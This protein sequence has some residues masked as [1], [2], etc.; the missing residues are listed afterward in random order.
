MKRLLLVLCIAVIFA[1]CKANEKEADQTA[2]NVYSE[3]EQEKTENDS[4]S[5][6]TQ[7]LESFDTVYKTEGLLGAIDYF[8]RQYD[9]FNEDQRLSY[10]KLI[11]EEVIRRSNEYEVLNNAI[12]PMDSVAPPLYENVNY[13]YEGIYTKE[14]NIIYI[15][16]LPN[17]SNYD[18]FERLSEDDVFGLYKAYWIS[19]GNIEDFGFKVAVEPDTYQKMKRALEL[20]YEL[21]YETEYY[22]DN[23]QPV[24]GLNNFSKLT[25]DIKVGDT[26]LKSEAKYPLVYVEKNDLLQVLKEES[27]TEAYL[28]VQMD[29]VSRPFQSGENQEVQSDPMPLDDSSDESPLLASYDSK[30]G[31]TFYKYKSN[32]PVLFDLDEDG[33]KETITY[34]T[35][36][37][38]I[39]VEGYDPIEVDVMFAETEYFV[40]LRFSDTY[41]SKLNLIGIIDFG[42][43]DDYTTSFYGIVQTPDMNYGYYSLGTIPGMITPQQEYD[44]TKMFDFNFKAVYLDHIGINAPVRLDIIA[45]YHTWFGR[46][47]FT[48][49][50]ANV[51]LVDHG[52]IGLEHYVTSSKLS[53]IRDM[54][55]YRS[56]DLVSDTV[57]LRA[58]SEVEMVATDNKEW[59]QVRV[60]GSLGWVHAEDVNEDHFTGFTAYD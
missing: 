18:I 27:K 26:G 58:G 8:N 2:K 56:N 45:R 13:L 17:T 33:V 7:D 1:G 35:T 10:A 39:S 52:I 21:R 36:K 24:Q 9:V 57:V 49:S 25:D 16:M 48:Y 5:N 11:V 34:N 19:D 22:D 54:I 51:S 44:E 37:G 59:I 15:N 12:L 55:A 30:N 32:V 20:V 41:D 23:D 38:L 6:A 53:V 4:T 31:T 28:P 50:P 46:N 42:P 40:I 3:A 29:F 60:N 43:S 14:E 47:T